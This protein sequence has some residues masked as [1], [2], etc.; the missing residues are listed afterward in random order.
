M[1]LDV[2]FH[3][4]QYKKGVT[5]ILLIKSLAKRNSIKLKGEI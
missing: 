4:K 3:S 1:S 2:K 5:A